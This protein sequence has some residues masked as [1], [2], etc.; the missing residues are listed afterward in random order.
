MKTL[1]EKIVDETKRF[2]VCLVPGGLLLPFG[3]KIMEKDNPGWVG[4]AKFG[5]KN[6]FYGITS[7][8]VTGA[9]GIAS[10][11]YLMLAF[12]TG[13][14]NP[15]D[16]SKIQEQQKKDYIFRQKQ[17]IHSTF[18]ETAGKDSV[19]DYKEFEKFYK[20]HFYNN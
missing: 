6:L 16:W 1:T 14:L 9:Y 11:I 13:S 15:A 5:K 10:S 20:E 17:L 2:G 18:N 8:I 12:N 4:K 3:K 19:I 7:G